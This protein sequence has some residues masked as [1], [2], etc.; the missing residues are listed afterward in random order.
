M[1]AIEGSKAAPG[2]P[3]LDDTGAARVPDGIHAEAAQAPVTGKTSADAVTPA[4][5]K[6]RGRPS[7]KKGVSDSALVD[8]EG[9]PG[10]TPV[11]GKKGTRGPDSGDGTPKLKRQK[12]AKKVGRYEEFKDAGTIPEPAIPRA[13]A[14]EGATSFKAVVWNVG[15]LRGF[16][17]NDSKRDL[18][19]KLVE[20]ES[21]DMIGILETKLQEGEQVEIVKTQLKELLPDFIESAYYCS[22]VKKGYS[23]T[24]VLLRKPAVEVTPVKLESGDDEGRV[25]CSEFADFFVVLAYV[26]NSGEKLVR[27]EERT[28][29][30]DP[31]LREYLK[32]LEARGK[33]VLL[34]GDLN[35]AH[36]DEDI[37]NSEAPH[38]PKSAGTSPEER[39]SFG[40]LL[41]AG[42]VDAFA[43]LH[44]E[45][46]G[47]F[48]YWSVRAGNR[49]KNRGLRLDYAVVSQQLVPSLSGE[50]QTSDKPELLDAFHFPDFCPQGDHCA[51]GVHL[52]TAKPASSA[53]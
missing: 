37:W 17:N 32:G 3:A 34:L 9:P 6:G 40:K 51:V 45:A 26:P 52:I 5:K 13:K 12:I 1:S 8:A 27:L 22:K 23:G 18:L 47:Q 15:G 46:L 48:S 24:C 20:Q 29:A 41:E 50:A 38:I 44:A 25:I 16:L 36:R 4:T 35:V 42:F 21:P 30:W 14:P 7:G 19:K 33:P 39:E 11:K 28:K 2:T 53:V 43:H 31:A 10:D 49:P